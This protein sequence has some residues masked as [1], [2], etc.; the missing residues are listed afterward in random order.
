[1]GPGKRSNTNDESSYLGILHA[2]A[3]PSP[4]AASVYLLLHP[5]PQASCCRDCPIITTTITTCIITTR[6]WEVSLSYSVPR[7]ARRTWA[8]SQS[9]L[10]RPSHHVHS[11]VSIH[12]PIHVPSTTLLECLVF[13]PEP[14]SR[15]S[16]S[17]V[18]TQDSV[19]DYYRPALDESS[20][21]GCPTY[22]TEQASRFTRPP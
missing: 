12:V 17:E 6:P 4:A 21:K 11:I 8:V 7:Q 9:P 19:H 18:P 5:S 15:A 14:P 13:P 16:S 2:L 1:M 10:L 3:Q 22:S 20:C